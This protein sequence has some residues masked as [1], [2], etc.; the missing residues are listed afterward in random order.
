MGHS[1]INITMNLYAHV[2]IDSVKSEVVKYFIY[3]FEVAHG[4]SR[5]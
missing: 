2:L 4:F 3:I 5:A 1:D